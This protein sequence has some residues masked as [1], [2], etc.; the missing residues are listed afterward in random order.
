MIDVSELEA[1]AEKLETASN[2]M[3][4]FSG[5]ILEEA[6]KEFLDIV[7]EEIM[8]AEHLDTRLM[9]ESF[10]RGAGYNIF[11]LDLGGLTLNVGTRVEY[12]KW[13]NE[14]HRQQ[15]GRF[16]PGVWKGERFIYTP[17]A[18]TGIVLKA[19]RTKGSGFFDKSAEIL[20]RMFPDIAEAKIQ[21]FI[22]RHF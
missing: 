8:R 17:G 15:P 12:A 9:L 7:Q 13:V 20:K 2:E 4:G 3:S 22:N 14:G 10:R 18:K 1:Y 16:I 11:D 19:S 5:E 6:G 21:D